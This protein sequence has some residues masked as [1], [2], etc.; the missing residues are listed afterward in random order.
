MRLCSTDNEIAPLT[1]EYKLAYASDLHFVRAITFK[2]MP[3]SE[4][5]ETSS[6]HLEIQ[7]ALLQ[8]R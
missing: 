3:C 4:V 7:V 5:Y 1:W 2:F 8:V 6:T